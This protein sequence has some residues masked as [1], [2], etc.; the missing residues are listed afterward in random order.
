MYK[1]LRNAWKRPMESLGEIQKEHIIKWRGEPVVHRIQGPTRLD[2]ARSLGYKAK[3]GI[4]VAR[5]RVGMGGRKTPNMPGGRRPKR[6]GRFFSLN[7]PKQQ[8]AE[9][10]A[11][12]RFKNMH[13]LN[14]YWV[15]EDGQH[16]WYEVI[17][18]DASH[19]SIKKDKSLK[20]LATG[21][22]TGRE[23]RGLTSSGR[24]SRGLAHK[25][26]KS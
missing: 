15:G 26:K 16:K 23:N 2:R 9:E 18:A 22:Q 21:K 6:A 1:F 7:K 25:G 13:V 19:P 3:Q 24:K 17:L 20:H 10:K 12:R 8:N 4:V 5:V 11:A 14:S